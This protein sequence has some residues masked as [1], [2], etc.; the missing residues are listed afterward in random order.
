M[1]EFVT[2]VQRPD[3]S[4]NEH[5]HQGDAPL[6]SLVKKTFTKKQTKHD[7]LLALLMYSD[8]NVNHRNENGNTAL[9]LAAEVISK[10]CLRCCTET[11]T[12]CMQSTKFM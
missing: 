2:L 4:V 1:Q 5:N 12:A 10:C 11:F 3:I 7:L 9:H 6:H 8:V